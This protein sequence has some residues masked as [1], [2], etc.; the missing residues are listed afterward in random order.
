MKYYITVILVIA[1]STLYGKIYNV[2][3]SCSFEDPKS[4]Y[5]A[6]QDGGSILIG[7]G[8]YE[9]GNWKINKRISV[10]GSEGAHLVSVE[11]DE[12][13]TITKN[14]VTISGLIFS[15]VTTNYLKE[16]AAIKISGCQNFVLE[17]NTII[18][19]F[20]AIYIAKGKHGVVKDN[21][22]NGN[23]STEAAS[24]NG[25]HAWSCDWLTIA[26]NEIENHRDEIYL[27]FVN[28]SLVKQNHSHS[29]TRYGL[30]YMFS[31]D[32]VYEEN[33]IEKNGVGVAVMFS[34]RITM[35]GNTFAYN[36]APTA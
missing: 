3:P 7:K 31:N 18:D 16:N 2:C 1:G 19:C 23:A 12:I 35:K 8:R 20:F 36:W 14:D 5:E 25:I 9:M 21:I 22:I 24:G 15:G 28:N 10:Y 34:R 11:G 30:H 26:E 27:E 29:N 4:A 13:L 17:N 33:V 32:D 6:S